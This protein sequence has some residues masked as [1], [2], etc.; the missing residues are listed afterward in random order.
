MSN[1]TVWLT[2]DGL[3][4]LTAAAAEAAPLETGGMLLGWSNPERNEIV[5]TTIIGPGHRAQHEVEAF[6][7]DSEWQQ[8][9]LEAHY[10]GSSGA[11]TYL[12]DWH[13]HPNGGFGL[14]RRDRRTLAKI[15][16]HS[17]ARCRTPLMGLL[18]A[19]GDGYRFGVWMRLPGRRW[20]FGADVVRLN[21]R[22]WSP[23]SGEWF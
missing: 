10:E 22:V 20:R 2:R 14:S 5:I 13:V 3:D 7:P 1:P 18:A 17:D 12:G 11:V 16:A 6:R 15:A 8:R 21:H 9:Q 19:A 4:E 23:R